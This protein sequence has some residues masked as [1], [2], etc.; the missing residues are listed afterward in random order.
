MN[1]NIV[2]AKD[3]RF[4]PLQAVTRDPRTNLAMVVDVLDRE[5]KAPVRGRSILNQAMHALYT[6][7][8]IWEG[9]TEAYPVLPECYDWVLKHRHLNVAATE[10]LLDRLGSLILSLGVKTLAWRRGWSPSDLA[11]YCIDF[12]VRDLSE[13]GKGV[14][15]TPMLFALFHAEV[16]RGA[17]N[18]PL[19]LFC[20]LDDAQ[21]LLN[22]SP[23]SDEV[24]PLDELVGITRG[25]GRGVG[26]TV[27]SSAGLS[28]KQFSNLVT[29]IY[30]RQGSHEDWNTVAAE[31]S[32]NAAQL[33]F[34]RHHQEPGMFVCQIAEGDWRYPF[35]FTVP[36][37]K[38]P[39]TVTD[40]E[41][42]DS[43]REL[44][45]LPTVAAD[46]YA[47]WTPQHLAEVQSA[48]PKNEFSL[49]EAD[50]RLLAAVIDRPGRPT[51]EYAKA[52]GMSGSRAA[53]IRD[54]LTDLG[55]LRQHRLATGGRGR[56]ATVLESLAPAYEAV[57]AARKGGAS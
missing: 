17:V 12:E 6:K 36:H 13:I 55:Y 24:A 21:R 56:A 16:E 33:E 44:E 1:L 28:R 23:A 10:A 9:R 49:S 38:I 50:F 34:C 35:L 43:V 29:K 57:K 30:G 48:R 47:K 11:R 2:S 4:N 25:T 40:E 8:G 22:T 45:A 31:S 5:L 27:Q 20:L 18:G 53:E 7:Y 39:A 26:F 54:R 32:L 51:S 52:A 42:A 14:L 15:L 46:E 37:L 3:W 41:A 19:S